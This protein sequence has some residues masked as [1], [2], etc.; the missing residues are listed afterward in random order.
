MAFKILKIMNGSKIL[1]GLNC[2]KNLEK[3]K[4]RATLKDLRLKKVAIYKK[5][6]ERHQLI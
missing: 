1:I 2:N 5:V 6:I 3:Y 4:N